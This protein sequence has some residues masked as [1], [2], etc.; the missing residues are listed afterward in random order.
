MA[1]LSGNQLARLIELAAND[2]VVAVIGANTACW[3]WV[4]AAG[5][6]NPNDAHS[7]EQLYNALNP[8]VVDQ[9][10]IPGNYGNSEP[11]WIE[12]W[13][14]ARNEARNEQLST[15][16]EKF[17]RCMARICAR[18]YGFTIGAPSS[19]YR[20]YVTVPRNQWY[21]WQHWGL[22]FHYNG[23]TAY[24]Q[25][26]TGSNVEVDDRLWEAERPN[27]ITTHIPITEISA[28]HLHYIARG[29]Q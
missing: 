5:N 21:S 11:T 28:N 9:P 24:V 18:N 13:N 26:D 4:L 3:N 17:M 2:H 16:R 29:I 1:I 27:H 25:K 20:I 7:P 22:G 14:N 19:A 6:G 8:E 10:V 12:L 23:A 15:H